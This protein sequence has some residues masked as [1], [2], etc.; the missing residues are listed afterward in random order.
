MII[1]SDVDMLTDGDGKISK[2][3]QDVLSGLLSKDHGLQKTYRD[4]F[5]LSETA[6][7]HTIA[8]TARYLSFGYQHFFP[9]LR[10]IR[11]DFRGKGWSTKILADTTKLAGTTSLWN[12]IPTNPSVCVA[13]PVD[14]KA[15]GAI[16]KKFGASDDQVARIIAAADSPV[17]VSWYAK[18][19]LHTPLF[20]VPLKA[21]LGRFRSQ[22]LIKH[23]PGHHRRQGARIERQGRGTFSHQS[24]P[25]Q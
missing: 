23:I 25:S 11:F 6:S 17:A 18:S 21:P 19:H 10:A 1:L 22:T 16:L 20:L 3:S 24:G 2:K 13:L 8:A 15:S 9:T 7:K 12:A 14:W 4:R 5:G